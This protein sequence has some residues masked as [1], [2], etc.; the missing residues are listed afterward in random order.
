MSDQKSEIS[1]RTPEI[2][3]QRTDVQGR[4]IRSHILPRG[5]KRFRRFDHATEHFFWLFD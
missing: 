4:G 3:S 5:K 2:G 1:G